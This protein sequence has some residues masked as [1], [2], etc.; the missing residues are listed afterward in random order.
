MSFALNALFRGTTQHAKC[1]LQTG[2]RIV[3]VPNI[4]DKDELFEKLFIKFKFIKAVIT[5][6]FILTHF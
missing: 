3:K 1:A 5:S 2:T 4:L 6:E